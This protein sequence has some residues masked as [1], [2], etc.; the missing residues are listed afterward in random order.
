MAAMQVSHAESYSEL[1]AKSHRARS[2]IRVLAR[3]PAPLKTRRAA[4]VEK[5]FL[6]FCSG[7]GR[8]A[9][10]RRARV[11]AR[12]YLISRP[13]PEILFELGPPR[14]RIHHDIVEFLFKLFFISNNP[15][16]V[17]ILPDLPTTSM[18]ALH[19]MSSERLPGVN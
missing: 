8:R 4:P 1:A 2:G 10:H 18:P 5:M 3:R 19:R 13:N 16:E 15:I 6:V 11:L 14:P 17:L 9:R 7:A 12:A